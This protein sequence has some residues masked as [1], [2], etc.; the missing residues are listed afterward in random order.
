M[1]LEEQS[2]LDKYIARYIL[3][4]S[5]RE[6]ADLA[7]TSPE[8]VI[9]RAEE[10][11]DEVDALTLDTKIHFLMDRLNAI[12]IDAQ[13]DAANAADAKDKGS[14]YSAAVSAIRESM[15]Q[16]NLFKKENES[17]VAELNQKRL[18]ELLRLFDVVIARGVEEIAMTNNLD[19][20]EL[21]SVFQSKI[22]EAAKE[23]EAR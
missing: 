6:I 7:G 22:V 5:P 2:T 1:E 4:K 13:N 21:L 17:A 12:A 9:A 20:K 11:K 18:Q 8:R 10:M 14:L 23:I 19:D 16:L 15:K 3:V